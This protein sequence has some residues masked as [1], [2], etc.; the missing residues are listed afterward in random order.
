MLAVR[1]D[2][3]LVDPKLSNPEAS[4][5]GGHSVFPPP[6]VA[7]RYEPINIGIALS[8]ESVKSEE[9]ISVTQYVLILG[10]PRCMMQPALYLP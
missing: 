10:N 1:L 4:R 2:G 7:L 9:T 8:H 5:K 3:H 6:F